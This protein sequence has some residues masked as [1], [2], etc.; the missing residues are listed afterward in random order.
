MP[1][2]CTRSIAT[3]E[4][5]LSPAAREFLRGIPQPT[6]GYLRDEIDEIARHPLEAG[7]L[8]VEETDPE[9]AGRLRRDDAVPG[10]AIFYVWFGPAVGVYVTSIDDADYS[11]FLVRH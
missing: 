6:K 1:S 9:L 11:S 8:D 7:E 10:Y 5:S 2:R 3:P 4:P